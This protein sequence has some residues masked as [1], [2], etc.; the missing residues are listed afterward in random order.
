MKNTNKFFGLALIAAIALN[1]LLITACSD[2]GG[3]N[4][5]GG[6]NNG[7]TDNGKTVLSIVITGLP[8][9]TT[10][11][12]GD[13]LDTS[14]LV[15]KALYSDGTNQDVTG[16]TTNF[17]SSTAGTKTVTVSYG[18]KTATTT[19]TVTVYAK[20]ASGTFNSIY[21]FEVW[22]TAQPNNTATS[23]HTAKLNVS[24]LEG[25]SSTAGSV[26]YII[27]ANANKYLSLDLSGS[28]ITSIG[29]VLYDSPFFMCSNLTGVTI[30]N[31]VT[32]ALNDSCA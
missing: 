27:K 32:I 4:D 13:R 14:G 24:S 2:G 17:D 25:S 19:F 9:K 3:G 23:P 16:Y 26:G 21:D 30:P 31:S 18:G 20:G 10:Y 15:V 5:N 28:S 7:G 6:N 8:T 1:A 22:L 12:V 11:V 29:G